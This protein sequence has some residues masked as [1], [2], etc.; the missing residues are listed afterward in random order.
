MLC[1]NVV[2]FGHWA[3]YFYVHF[4]QSLQNLRNALKKTTESV[5][6]ITSSALKR[7]ENSRRKAALIRSQST[8]SKQKFT[9]RGSK[10][11]NNDDAKKILRTTPGKSN[12][13]SHEDCEIIDK[14]FISERKMDDKGDENLAEK[15]DKFEKFPGMLII[16]EEK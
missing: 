9:P 12:V 14:A 11:L 2:F 10:C 5:K 8:L 4:K 7:F 3:Y 6:Q 13:G 1:A 16:Q 15:N